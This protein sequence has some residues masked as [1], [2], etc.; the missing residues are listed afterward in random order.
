LPPKRGETKKAEAPTR[1]GEI[2]KHVP[3]DLHIWTAGEEKQRTGRE[4]KGR[5]GKTREENGPP[6]TPSR[7]ESSAQ[8][9]R[10]PKKK[11]A[12]GLTLHHDRVRGTE[13]GGERKRPRER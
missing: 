10:G 12:Q 2:F 8:K 6:G 1:K 3:G 11:T 5:A 13:T 9:K 7:V 4:R